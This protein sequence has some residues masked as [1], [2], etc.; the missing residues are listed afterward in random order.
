MN[1]LSLTSIL[2]CSNEL[3]SS[4]EF[5]TKHRIG[6][7][8]TRSRKL[9]FSDLIYY[10]LRSVH[11]SISINY[12]EFKD[13]FTENFPNSILVF[14]RGYP[15]EDLFR[16]LDSKGI[17][18]LMRI[19]KSFKKA[20]FEA[21]DS[22][23]KYTAS[24]NKNSLTLRSIHFLLENETTEYLVTNIMSEQLSIEQFSELYRLCW[25]G[26]SKYRELKNRLEIECFNSIKPVCIKQEFFAAMYL[27][28]LASIV[29][30]KADSMIFSD[31]RNKHKYQSSRSQILNRIKSSII[32]L[33]KSTMSMRNKIITNLII[34]ATK[35]LS[36]IR[37][38]RKFGRYKKNT[39][40]RYHNHIKSCI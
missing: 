26:E 5:C 29:K 8:F 37:S 14:D 31:P 33:L 16:F 2:K 22:L 27:S 28:N 21:N 11:K 17:L 25:G 36:I 32:L 19:P 13:S 39:R 20:I 23:F 38:S 35:N 1:R 6:S 24:K 30:L 40:W 7:A 10:I 18:F 15:S 4:G 12:S 34:E 3:I 9:S